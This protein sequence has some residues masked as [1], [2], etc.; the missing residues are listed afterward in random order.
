MEI[1]ALLRDSRRSDVS[2]VYNG[3]DSELF[4]PVP[5]RPHRRRTCIFVGR[6]EDRKKGVGTLL[7]AM[8]LLPPIT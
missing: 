6:T 8:T 1:R 7:E 2:V 3:T 4:H 5:E